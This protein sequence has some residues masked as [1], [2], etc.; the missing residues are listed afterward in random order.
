MA[1]LKRKNTQPPGGFTYYQ[2]E[3][4]LL[5]K[6]DNLSELIDRVIAHR[7]YKNLPTGDAEEVSLEI[8]RQICTRLGRHECSAE[9][10]ADEWVPIEHAGPLVTLSAITGFSAAAL[11]WIK[12]GGELVPIEEA[13]RRREICISCPLNSP[14]GGCKCSA[15]YNL[16][17]SIVPSERQLEDLHVCH[18]CACSLQAKVHL[19]MN[20]VRESNDGRKLDFPVY[21]WQLEES[22]ETSSS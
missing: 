14:V 10:I 20:V 12:S 18:A 9:G 2:K 8:Q 21:C 19:P 3:T 7:K 11:E 17:A 4:R 16:V 6:G 13:Q 1:L 15:F 5:L 22:G